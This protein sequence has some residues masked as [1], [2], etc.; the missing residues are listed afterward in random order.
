MKKAL[1]LMSIV[2]LAQIPAFAQLELS[3]R[4][5]AKEAAQLAFKSCMTGESVRIQDTL[6]KAG[7][8]PQAS[9][10]TDSKKASLKADLKPGGLASKTDLKSGLKSDVGGKAKS[11][12]EAQAAT[13]TKAKAPETKSDIK[14]KAN[15][16]GQTEIIS[17]RDTEAK[18]DINSKASHES[19]AKAAKKAAHEN[20]IGTK[21][22][23]KLIPTKVSETLAP[24]AAVTVEKVAV[25]ESTTEEDLIEQEIKEQNL[26]MAVTLK[27]EKD[28]KFDQEPAL[29]LEKVNAGAVEPVNYETIKTEMDQT[30]KTEEVSLQTEAN[31]QLD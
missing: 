18:V 27:S 30:E 9:F 10:K 1:S 7:S 23:K 16:N 11:V 19:K 31:I 22:P 20:K 29:P 17:K 12:V 2:T 3:C 28:M 8:P 24:V 25:S 6:K 5:K 15:F 26:E 4:A 21:L 13:G 14:F